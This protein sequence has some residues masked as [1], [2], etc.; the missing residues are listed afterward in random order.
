MEPV[1]AAN[2]P[3]NLQI[4]RKNSSLVAF[5]FFRLSLFIKLNE[6]LLVGFKRLIYICQSLNINI[7]V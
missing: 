4:D 2:L 3:Q 7:E 6:V 5:N 1:L